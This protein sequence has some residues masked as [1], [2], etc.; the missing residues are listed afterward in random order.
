MSDYMMQSTYLTHSKQ[1]ESSKS[2][3]QSAMGSNALLD[4]K[5]L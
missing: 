4:S 3:Q 5:E 2:Y 1:G